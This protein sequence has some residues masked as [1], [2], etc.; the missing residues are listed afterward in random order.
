VALAGD[1]LLDLVDKA[2]EY[3]LVERLEQM[4]LAWKFNVLCAS[5]VFGKVASLLDRDG[6][7]GASTLLVA[8]SPN[9]EAGSI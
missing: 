3:V 4:V 5:D 9:G 2:I 8:L 6:L 7:V 1:E